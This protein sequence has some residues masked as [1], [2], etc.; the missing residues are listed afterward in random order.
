MWS[1]FSERVDCALRWSNAAQS[2]QEVKKCYVCENKD[3]PF[4]GVHVD[5]HVLCFINILMRKYRINS[6]GFSNI[7]H[8]SNL[9]QR[10]SVC[11]TR[12]FTTAISFAF[13]SA[14]INIPI[15]CRESSGRWRVSVGNRPPHGLF[16]KTK[17]YFCHTRC[18]I[19]P[20]A[21]CRSNFPKG[22]PASSHWRGGGLCCSPSER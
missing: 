22:F 4:N 5:I 1:F 12:Q 17:I 16:S 19:I 2:G 10:V 15:S 11:V 6:H 7:S 20:L 18:K 8:V 14:E 13:Y 9:A 3:L 21:R